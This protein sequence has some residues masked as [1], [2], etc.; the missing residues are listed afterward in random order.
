[1]T[2]IA[3]FTLPRVRYFFRWIVAGFLLE[4][5]CPLYEL[6]LC[7]HSAWQEDFL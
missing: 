1:M 2:F 6:E 7:P 5:K 4:K 3:A